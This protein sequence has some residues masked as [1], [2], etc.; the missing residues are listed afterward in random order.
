MKVLGLI[1]L[2]ITILAILVFG[3]AYAVYKIAFSKRCDGDKRLKYF[4]HDDFEGLNAAP[5]SFTS[6]KGQT[7]RGN[8]YLKSGVRQPHA[9]IIFSHGMGG[10]HLSYI[11]EI[12]TLANA[13]FAVL[14]YD[15]TGTFFSEGKSLVG[16]YQGV[17]DLKAAI[18][19]V[20][21]NEKLKGLKKILVGHSWGGYSVCQVL[22]Y[23][24]LDI[25]GAVSFSAPE[26]SYQ[27][28]SDFFGNASAFLSPV[29]KFACALADGPDSIKKCSD[30]L[31][32]TNG[33]PVLLLHG[34]CDETVKPVSSPINDNRLNDNNYITKI[35]YEGKRHNVYQTKESEE[36]LTDVFAG[37]NA[38]KKQKNPSKEEIDFC[39]DIDYELITREDPTV[40]RTVI[41]FIHNCLQGADN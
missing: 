29:F 17:T 33:I 23:N 27:I 22:K 37:I 9:L 41:N 11:T 14:A 20:N 8:L 5:V 40:M 12:N 34:D 2:I 19:W 6:D 31:A 30:I 24:S 36:Y 35:M 21:S 32:N 28:V 3:G 18:D 38:L 16:F 10:G 13:G 26:A 1:L 25:S 7:L 4:S 39:Y 15:N